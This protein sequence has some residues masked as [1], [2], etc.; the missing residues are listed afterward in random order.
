MK[1]FGW[2]LCLCIFIFVTIFIVSVDSSTQ[3]R[4]VQFSN[5]DFQI[6]NKGNKISN[7]TNT[8]INLTSSNI[9]NKQINATNTNI[10][11]SDVAIKTDDIDINSSSSFNNRNVDYSNDY[12][13]N[14]QNT[15]VDN[16]EPLNFKNLDNSDLDAV[17]N[18]AQNY[19]SNAKEAYNKPFKQMHPKT[20]YGYKNIDWSTW[21]SNFVNQILDDSLA[22][23]E[24][25]NYGYGTLIYYSFN[26]DKTGRIS[27]IQIK[28][29]NVSHEDKQKL[30]QLIQSYEYS[31][32]TTFP[33]NSQRQTAKVSAVMMLSNES[34]YSNPG[35]FNEFERVKFKL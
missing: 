11:T 35:D 30:A 28:S 5:Q 23:R 15:N 24:L 3:R 8:K 18:D 14:N 4:K 19:S 20:R 34:Q 26:V 6:N 27:D 22:I 2:L 13:Y 9:N 10:K 17:L 21:K 25:D 12:G 32:M 29:I 31:E 1:K 16:S 33:A 7:N